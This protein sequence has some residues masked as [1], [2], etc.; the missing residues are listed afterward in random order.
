[1]IYGPKESDHPSKAN[2]A[3][4][5]TIIT[6]VLLAFNEKDVEECI[7]KEA[8]FHTENN[9][10]TILS[11][12]VE[13]DKQ[14]MHIVQYAKT[15]PEELHM[16]VINATEDYEKD[17][18][19]MPYEL[20][21]VSIAGDVS[22]ETV[23][24]LLIDCNESKK[25]DNTRSRIKW[26]IISVVTVITVTIVIVF[27]TYYY[28]IKEK[29][30]IKQ[31][32]E[33]FEQRQQQSQQQQ[34]RQQTS[35]KTSSRKLNEMSDHTNPSSTRTTQITN[36]SDSK[37]IQNKE[38]RKRERKEKIQMKQNELEAIHERIDRQADEEFQQEKKE[39]IAFYK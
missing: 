23:K 18:L 1:M 9:H 29:K 34:Q 17:M 6:N 4:E 39:L 27:G 12:S 20:C 35:L 15:I 33:E 16:K 11:P 3:P 30:R 38:K 22:E 7:S 36:S 37:L 31:K 19:Q 25:K 8:Y 14:L 32:Q 13:C 2:F 10:L 21:E 5:N 26:L 24:W 28:Y